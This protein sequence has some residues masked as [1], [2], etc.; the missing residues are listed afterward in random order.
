MKLLPAS[1]VAV[2]PFVAVAFAVI[3]ATGVLLFF[4]VKNGPVMVLHEWFGWAFVL[5]GAVHLLLNFRP[6]LAYLRQRAG[7]MSLACALFLVALLF[8]AGLH[9]PDHGQH[10]PPAH[11]DTAHPTELD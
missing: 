7:V 6:L 8:A 5:G 9:H 4:H 11:G 3:A 10:R 2:S 1:K